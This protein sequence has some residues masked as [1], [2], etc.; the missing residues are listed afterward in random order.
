MAYDSCVDNI[1]LVESGNFLGVR[2]VR[3]VYLIM[4][5]QADTT[6]VPSCE[7]FS[8]I[9]LVAFHQRKVD[10]EV[11][12]S[13]GHPDRWNSEPPATTAAC[14]VAADRRENELGEVEESELEAESTSCRQVKKRKRSPRLTTFEVSELAVSKGIKDY[15]QLLVL[16]KGL[17]AFAGE[18]TKNSGGRW[19][20]MALDIPWRNQIERTHFNTAVRDL[21]KN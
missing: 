17:N 2:E 5:S 14:Q 19:L 10:T 13:P 16:A 21:L 20:N 7:K 8:N 15:L 6:K 18:C 11:L 3:R 4:Y 9:V 1:E 12:L